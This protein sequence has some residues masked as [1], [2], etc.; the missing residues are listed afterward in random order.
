MTDAMLQDPDPADW[1]NWRRTLD[2]QGHSPL[3][4]ITTEN[5]GPPAARLELGHGPRQPAD[6]A[7]RSR[8]HHVPGQ[9]RRDGAGARRRRRGAPLDLP[10]GPST[11]GDR[12][13]DASSRPAAPQHRHLRRPDLPEHVGRTRGGDRRPD[14]D[15][16]L[17]HRRDPGGELPVH[18]RLDRRRRADRVRPDRVRRVPGRHLLHRRPRRRHRRGGVAHVDHRAAGRPG[19]AI[20]GATCR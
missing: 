18:E 12:R 5:V 16:G 3:D 1:L 2:G 6:D 17:G 7:D 19:A 14:G 4:Q 11:G 8:R 10:P 15:G 20:P 13:R 9:P